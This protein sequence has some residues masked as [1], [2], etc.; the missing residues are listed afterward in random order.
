MNDTKRK[1][2][3]WCNDCPKAYDYTCSGAD[4][5][6][7]DAER[8]ARIYNESM[9]KQKPY[10]EKEPVK[11]QPVKWISVKDRLPEIGRSVLIYYPKWDGDEIQVAKLEDDGMMFD[12]CG[13]FNIGTGVVTHWIPLPEPP[14]DG[15][16][17]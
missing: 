13:E 7:C 12:I 2:M 1:Y 5:K 8:K 16:A 11:I 14:K 6:R 10:I 9:M 15:D 3:Q 4:A 17:E